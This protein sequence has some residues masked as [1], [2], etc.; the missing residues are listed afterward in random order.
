MMPI[1]PYP[2]DVLD[3]KLRAEFGEAIASVDRI[4]V[5]VYGE[6]CSELE[7]GCATCTAWAARDT[8]FASIAI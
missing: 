8:L 7:S 2:Q 3:A 4:I 5:K 1:A 6:R